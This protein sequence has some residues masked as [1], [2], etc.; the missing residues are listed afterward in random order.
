MD[1]GQSREDDGSA[2]FESHFYQRRGFYKM[3]VRLAMLTR[4]EC[5]AMRKREDE[6]NV[7]EMHK[8]SWICGVKRDK[9]GMTT[10]EEIHQ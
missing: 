10:Y 9:L 2:V 4:A 8:L 7:A 1:S 3:Q 6:V 5:W